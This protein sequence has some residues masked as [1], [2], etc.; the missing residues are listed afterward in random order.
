MTALE[1][2]LARI[3]EALRLLALDPHQGN[4]IKGAMILLRDEE[5]LL[6]QAIWHEQDDG[7]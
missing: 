1:T 5:R 6:K 4:N 3:Q 7:A 2:A